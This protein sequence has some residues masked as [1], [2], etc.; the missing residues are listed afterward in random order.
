VLQRSKFSYG[1]RFTSFRHPTPTDR[2]RHRP[3]PG[4]AAD[5]RQK[6]SRR[7]RSCS[8][9]PWWRSRTTFLFRC[10]HEHDVYRVVQA[11]RTHHSSG[12]CLSSTHEWP[13]LCKG[14]G[15][16]ASSATRTSSVHDR[17][18]EGDQAR[19]PGPFWMSRRDECAICSLINN[20]LAMGVMGSAFVPISSCRR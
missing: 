10:S 13:S 6:D 5:P 9:T 3:P 8:G 15:A 4:A 17:E 1:P 7:P 18:A 19:T 16:R 20:P 14:K 12:R 2:C 11:E